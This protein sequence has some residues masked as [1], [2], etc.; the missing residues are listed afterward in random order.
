MKGA[1]SHESDW[2][3]HVGKMALRQGALSFAP[4]ATVL[5]GPSL[6]HDPLGGSLISLMPIVACNLLA[7]MPAGTVS[8]AATAEVIETAICSAFVVGSSA[9]PAVASAGCIEGQQFGAA[10]H[11]RQMRGGC[12]LARAA[13]AVAHS[14]SAASCGAGTASVTSL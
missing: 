9:E 2:R 5:T 10:E 12:G 4:P 8:I 7:D 13:R 3:E 6:A 1:S 14:H 11:R